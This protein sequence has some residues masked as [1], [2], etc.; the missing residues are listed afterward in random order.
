M[1]ITLDGETDDWTNVP[2]VT[3]DK[4]PTLPAGNDTSYQFAVTADDKKLY[5]L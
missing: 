5:F 1:T 3:V 2:R 4:S